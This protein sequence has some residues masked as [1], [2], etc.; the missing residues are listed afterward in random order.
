MH[1]NCVLEDLVRFKTYVIVHII[2]RKFTKERLNPGTLA[3]SPAAL[4][5]HSSLFQLRNIESCVMT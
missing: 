4:K 5:E 1:T 3:I 2:E